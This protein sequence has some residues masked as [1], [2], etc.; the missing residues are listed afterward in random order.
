MSIKLS[1][2]QIEVLIKAAKEVGITYDQM[3]GVIYLANI[4]KIRDYK[5][6][7]KST[8]ENKNED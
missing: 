5:S 7:K 1:Q 2:E 6:N 3:Q 4:Q 8:G